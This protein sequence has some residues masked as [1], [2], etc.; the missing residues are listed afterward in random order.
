MQAEQPMMTRPWPTIAAHYERY[1]SPRRSG[2][3]LAALAHQIGQGPLSQ[4]LFAWT[5]MFDL[6]IVQAEVS[7]PYD[8][9]FLRLSPVSDDEIELRYMD[10]TKP[11]KQWHRTVDADNAY[12]RL[13]K[14]L[15]ELRWFH[16]DMLEAAI[17]NLPP[18]P[19]LP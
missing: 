7:Y 10:S 11:E 8:G 12:P 2:R 18:Q 13:L 5:S 1:A 4:G 6:C 16:P 9:S 14:F 17:S 19:R 15:D 3:A